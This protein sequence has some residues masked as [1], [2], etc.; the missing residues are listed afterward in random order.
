MVLPLTPTRKRK[1]RGN[2]DYHG[3]FYSQ[4]N[5]TLLSQKHWAYLQRLYHMGE[6]ELAV[7][8]LACRGSTNEDIA[9]VLKMRV[10]TVKTHLK[11]I[12]SKTRSRNRISMLLRFVDD[13]NK[14]FR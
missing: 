2:I 6:R 11:N 14:I 13:A 3:S 12:F 9:E 8:K 1:K 4:S 10:G 5:I 7:A